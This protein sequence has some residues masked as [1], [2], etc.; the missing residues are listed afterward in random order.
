[1]RPAIERVCFNFLRRCSMRC[2]FCYVPFNGAPVG[3]DRCLAV[4]DRCRELGA[5]IVTFCGGDPFDFSEFDRLLVAADAQGFEIHVDTNGLGLRRDHYD[6]LAATTSLLALPLDGA[7]PPTHAEM[8]H[9]PRHFDQV[10]SHLAALRDTSVRLKVNTLVSRQNAHDISAMVDL[11]IR[12]KPAIWSLYQF[13][14][15]H[16]ARHLSDTHVIERDAFLGLTRPLP[17]LC[18]PVSVEIAPVSERHGTYMFVGHDGTLYANDP[19]DESQYAFLGSIFD[20]AAVTS[21][22]KTCRLSV[23]PAARSRYLSLSVA[24]TTRV[25]GSTA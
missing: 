4:L 10:V 19:R 5:R 9:H 14:P 3:L 7:T 15:Q 24:T 8:R 13:W 12:L 18:S 20:D 25:S 17:T 11:I 22:Y 1:M 23:R 2:S 16:N 21:W 6:T